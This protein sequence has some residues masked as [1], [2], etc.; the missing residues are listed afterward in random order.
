MAKVEAHETATF[1][2]PVPIERARDLF[3]F[4]DQLRHARRDLASYTLEDAHR[5]RWILHEKREKGVTFQGDY[6]VAYDSPRPDLITWRS[7]A[8]NMDVKGEVRLRALAPN[9]TEVTYSETV[10]PDLP[11]PKLMATVF[12]PIVARNVR[13]GISEFIGQVKALLGA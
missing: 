12:K 1:V 9:S 4:P 13:E 3:Y 11:I 6:T 7:V 8:G 10:A 2:A 5:I